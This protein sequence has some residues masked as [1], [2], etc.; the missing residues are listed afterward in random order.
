MKLLYF[1]KNLKSLRKSKDLTQNEI[2]IILG[3]NKTLIPK[4]EL[5][6]TNPS[7]DT[8]IKIADYFSVSIDALLRQDMAVEGISVVNGKSGNN[9]H[10]VNANGDNHAVF[11]HTESEWAVMETKFNAA[12]Q[13]IKDLETQ[14]EL[15]KQTNA[16]KDELIAALKQ[17][18]NK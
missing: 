4:Y 9:I 3:I 10:Q 6:D 15:Q 11:N 1:G 2:S 18:N 13:R 5:N 16:A 8:L 7:I 12:V 14:I 17:N